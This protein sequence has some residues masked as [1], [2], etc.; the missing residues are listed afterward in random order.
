MKTCLL[1]MAALTS[2][3]AASG[4]D[5]CRVE[6]P[7]ARVV[8]QPTAGSSSSGTG[9]ASVTR[10]WSIDA[11]GEK[12]LSQS[13]RD[14][15][16]VSASLRIRTLDPCEGKTRTRIDQPFI[17]EV[18]V[19]GLL[20][21]DEFPAPFRTLVLERDTGNPAENPHRAAITGNGRTVLRFPASAITSSDPTKARGGEIFRVLS[22]D[23][24]ATAPCLASHA[25]EVLPVASASISGL[26]ADGNVSASS[27][28]HAKL[29]DVY[30]GSTIQVI[31]FPAAATSSSG[32]VELA[33]RKA[34]P[35]SCESF[36]IAVPHLLEHI[37]T[38]NPHTLAVVSDSIYGREILY[39]RQI[40]RAPATPVEFTV[41]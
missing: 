38:D 39:S 15:G 27:S 13:S 8:W 35:V 5:L 3:L 32:G 41:R 14:P 31:L 26:P 2:A 33:S 37:V 30:P 17:V 16:R 19:A 7:R 36:D 11:T 20:F 4:W 1:A 12:L 10:L 25:L 22:P 40:S 24:G 18:E 29:T 6:F 28:L 21:G 23:P 34:A 9:L